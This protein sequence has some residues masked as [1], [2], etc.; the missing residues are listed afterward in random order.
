ML[1]C[2]VVNKIQD[3]CP[4]KQVVTMERIVCDTSWNC[5]TLFCTHLESP[6]LQIIGVCFIWK[7]RKCCTD[8]A[9]PSWQ[10]QQFGRN[11][12]EG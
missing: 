6:S 2:I 10:S 11:V 4:E 8:K 3:V 5:S 12:K 1:M 7:L 9:S